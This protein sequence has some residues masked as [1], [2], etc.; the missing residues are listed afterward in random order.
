MVLRELTGRGVLGAYVNCAEHCSLYGALEH[1]IEGLRILRCERISTAF[2]LEQLARF[3]GKRPFVV[4]LDE[5]DK[6]PPRERGLLL[7]Y[8]ASI[9]RS[10]VICIS[11]T[12][13]SVEALTDQVRS[14]LS[15]VYIDFP[16]YT[17]EE[18]GGILRLRADQGLKADAC[19]DAV[20][21][22]IVQATSGDARSA[23]QVLW[24]AARSAA[25]RHSIRIE[26]DD[27]SGTSMMRL[28]ERDAHLLSN[29]SEHHRLLLKVLSKTGPLPATQL[30]ERYRGECARQS[31]HPVARRTFT[32]YMN[33]LSLMGFVQTERAE[34]KGNEHYF[35]INISRR[36]G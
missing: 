29:L 28:A 10:G 24:Q 17:M 19:G 8:L 6:V 20:L 7:T 15:A 9:G 27:V 34:G 5:I 2:K 21:P 14:R 26:A 12:P 33:R 25:Q 18:L 13:R 11:P 36:V 22:A 35:R 32:D 16:P 30:F 4:V 31:S 3:V 1:L 23:I